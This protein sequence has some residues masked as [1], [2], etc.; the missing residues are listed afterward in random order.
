[1][2]AASVVITGD[3]WINGSKLWASVDTMLLA[4]V[5]E[6]LFVLPEIVGGGFFWSTDLPL[7]SGV[8]TITVLSTVVTKSS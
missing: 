5:V 3:T 6:E 7:A 8:N 2:E 1:M 4:L